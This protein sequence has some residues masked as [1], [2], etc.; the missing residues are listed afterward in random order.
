MAADHSDR[1]RRNLVF[2][3]GTSHKFWQIELSGLS[4]TVCYGKVGTNGQTQ[5]KDFN[6]E[7]AAAKSYD[8]LLVE[9]LKKGYLESG[10]SA[11]ARSPDVAP[12]AS[13]SIAVLPVEE[14]RRRI[15]DWYRRNTPATEKRWFEH[16]VPATAESIEAC[17]AELGVHFPS[18]LRQWYLLED[19]DPDF[20]RLF[21]YGSLLSTAEIVRQSKMQRKIVEDGFG[22]ESSRISCNRAIRRKSW[23]NN[24]I[25]ITDSGSGDHY[26]VDMNPSKHGVVGQIFRYD[27]ERGPREILAASFDEFL[28]LFVRDLEAGRYEWSDENGQI[29][30]IK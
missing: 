21:H 29:M 10:S 5:T 9:K 30:P 17:E 12:I 15:L 1:P 6:T 19:G 26:C 13:T 27:H 8:K 24:W 22:L 16:S 4:H 25:P 3:E 11:V 2:Q 14:A 20:Y 23:D 7:E 28:S 18:P